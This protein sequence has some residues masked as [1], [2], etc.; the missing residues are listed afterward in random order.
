[1]APG[2]EL[3][4]PPAGLEV[5]SDWEGTRAVLRPVGGARW[6]VVGFL[7]LWLCGWA[8]GEISAFGALLGLLGV[9]IGAIHFHPASNAGFGSNLAF[10]GFLCFWLVFWTLG[11]AFALSTVL[12]TGWGRDVFL[13]R[14]GECSFEQRFGPF[15]KKRR[16]ERGSVSRVL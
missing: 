10:V 13:L 16:L 5:K 2:N 11:G 3:P 15:A 1:M 12:R 9:P 8:L 7:S 14:P 4:A 6:I